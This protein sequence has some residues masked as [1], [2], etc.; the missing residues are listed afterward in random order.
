M[1]GN[2]KIA[3][4]GI[5]LVIG[6]AVYGF[7]QRHESE[8]VK[9]P[10]ATETPVTEATV[11]ENSVEKY[12]EA[13]AENS[14]FLNYDMVIG[15]KDAPVEIIEYAAIS[16]PH[17]ARFHED[18]LP[19]LKKKYLDTGKARMI[20]RNFI[21]SNPFDVFASVLTRCVA[22]EKFFSTVAVY[23]D[24]QRTWNKLPEL[25]RIYDEKGQK[26][27]IEFARTQVAK[28]GEI[29]GISTENARK[30]YDNQAIIT[31]LEN[32][33]RQAVE[34]YGVN[35]TPTVIVNGKKLAGNDLASIEQAIMAATEQGN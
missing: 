25:K 35:S 12:L 29:A 4:F 3:L 20:Y 17:C 1:T 34:A 6:V 19:E 22:E 16:C 21:F 5:A 32:I 31:Y 26:V 15:A 27:A 30:C 14:G 11:T 8:Q 24:N 23:F 10:P 13:S 33:R 9:A 18:V 2:G 28:T 7:S